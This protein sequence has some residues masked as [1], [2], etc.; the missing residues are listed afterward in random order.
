MEDEYD[1]EIISLDQN[2]SLNYGGE[3]YG[4]YG[5]YDE[6]ME[7]LIFGDKI[8]QPVTEDRRGRNELKLPQGYDG[9][10]MEE[11]DNKHYYKL[12]FHASYVSLK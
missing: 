11:V 1:I 5:S 3:D 8:F 10:G 6:S 7:W 2:N 12:F 4:D 9:A